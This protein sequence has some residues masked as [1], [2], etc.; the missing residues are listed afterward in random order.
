MLSYR[1][2][3]TITLTLLMLFSL[4]PVLSIMASEKPLKSFAIEAKSLMNLGS[5]L[6]VIDNAMGVSADAQS[7]GEV[8]SIVPMGNGR[9]NIELQVIAE[10][11]GPSTYEV[12]VGDN[13]IEK[14]T[15]PAAK[16]RRTITK[17]WK[18]VEVNEGENYK[19]KVSNG[20]SDGKQYSQALWSKITF[21]QLD[22][23]PGKIRANLKG[24]RSQEEIE[25]GPALAVERQPDGDGSVVI[26]G[27]LRTWHPVTLTLDGPFAHEQDLQP[28]PFLD[29]RMSVTFAHESGVPT[30]TVPGYFSTDGN[31]AESSAEQGTKWRAHLSPDK[32]GVWSYR[33][34]FVA[35]EDAAIEPAKGDYLL[36]YQ[37]KFGTFEIK[38]TNK[39][40]RDFRAKGRLEYIGSHHLRHAGSGEYFLKAGPDAPETILAYKDFDNTISKKRHLPLKNWA[41]HAQDYNKGDPTWQ[42]GKGKNLIGALN[43]LAEK[44]VNAF[45]FL[46]Y[47]AGGDGDNVWPYVERNGKLHFDT[48]KL[49]QWNIVFSHA[50]AKGIYLHFK[51]QE[52][53]LDDN[54]KTARKIPMVIQESMD[55]GKLGTERKLYL[56]EIIARFGHHLALNWNL[57]EENT[58]TY[59]E[60]RDMAE[61][62]HNLDAYDHN[63]IIHSFPN[64]QEAVY[65]SLLGSQSVITGASLQNNWSNAHAKTL[66]WVDASRAAG[67][68]WVVANDEQNPARLGVPPDPGY[69]G[70]DGWAKHK[71]SQYNL[72]DIRKYT[73]WGNI[74]AGGAGVEYYFGYRLP[75]ND[76]NAQDFR[77]RDKS[78][79]YAGIAIDFFA[80]NEIP[81]HRM[82]NLNHLVG[83]LNRNNSMYCLG[84]EGEIY[85]VY[86]PKGGEAQ[87]DLSHEEGRFE[88]RWFNPRTGGKLIKSRVRSIKGGQT[89]SLGKPPE[90]SNEDWLVI[91]KN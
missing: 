51:L 15:V 83:N 18:E 19:I 60:Q 79:E 35:G 14:F 66:K 27:E 62:I 81:F 64:Q 71:K 34:S 41:P 49:D 28:N 2:Y 40:G 70:F 54:R 73:L 25:A 26:S 33:I 76:L 12:L 50:Q 74:M 63:L 31:A 42:G 80:D 45:S 11:A 1:R 84:N 20:S 68:P 30:Y 23:D 53:E 36:P 65:L 87:I 91:L 46:T 6:K 69:K 13:L 72:H 78:W 17:T 39:K 52:N 59:E 55:G 58:Q 24:L 9:F 90:D 5:S 56:R 77:S 21:F 8:E 10:P 82:R 67:K 75:E 89:V 3:R 61:Y 85:L 57:G 4:S 32:P 16:P 38:R 29:Y 44:R 86:L 7:K 43:Y 47:N 88:V 37:G 48:S 22:V